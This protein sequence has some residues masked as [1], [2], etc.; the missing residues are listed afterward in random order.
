MTRMQT[1]RA[2][3]ETNETAVGTLTTHCRFV[4]PGRLPFWGWSSE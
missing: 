2:S 4:S 1:F 3:V